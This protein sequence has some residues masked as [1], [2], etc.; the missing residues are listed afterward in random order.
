MI[1][2]RHILFILIAAILLSSCSSQK[3]PVGG[4]HKKDHWYAPSNWHL[5]SKPAGF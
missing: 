1:K 5:R 4:W 2:G 3:A